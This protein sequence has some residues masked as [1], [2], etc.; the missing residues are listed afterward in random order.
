MSARS[1]FYITTAI[2]YAN[3]A[4]HIGHAYERIATDAIAR[5]KRLDGYDVL[6]VTGMD[7]HGQKMQRTA[8]REGISPQQLAD[9]TAAQFPA[10]GALFSPSVR[11][12]AP[13]KPRHQ[14][15]S[16]DSGKDAGGGRHLSRQISRLVFG[17]RRSYYDAGEADRRAG[18]QQLAPTGSPVEWVEEESYFFRLSAYRIG[19]SS[20]TTKSSGFRDAGKI[21]QRNRCL[22][23]AGPVRSLNLPH[24]IRVGRAGAQRSKSCDVCVG[25][26]AHELYYWNRYPG[27]NAPR[28]KFWPADAHVIGK[29]ITR[30]HADLLAGVSDVGQNCGAEPGRRPWFSLQSGRENV[31]I[32][33]QRDRS[34]HARRT[35]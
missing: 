32:G 28:A 8:A 17:S 21:Q 29:D 14:A 7:E 15:A 1:P 10:M 19:C 2:P 25:R 4:P 24:H 26:C 6:F 18:R 12:C 9:R 3:G 11:S 34:V 13:R 5:F 33:R 31:E 16:R 30:F 27:P 23:Q 35:L 20:V 22:H